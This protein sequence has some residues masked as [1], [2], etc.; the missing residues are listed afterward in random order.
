MAS[1]VPHVLRATAKP[2][3]SGSFAEARRRAINLYRAWYREVRRMTHFK[4]IT[5]PEIGLD[6]D[7]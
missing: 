5:Q 2:I 3:L 7:R 4:E 6:R 1:R